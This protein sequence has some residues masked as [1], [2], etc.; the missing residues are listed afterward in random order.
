MP[1][2]RGYRDYKTPEEEG[3]DEDD[4]PGVGPVPLEEEPDFL[5]ERDE[6]QPEVS[7]D[8]REEMNKANEDFKK[9]FRE[10]GDTLEYQNLHYM[11]PLKTRKAPEVEAAIRLLYVQLR[12]EGRRLKEKTKLMA[13]RPLSFLEQEI[14][15]L[16]RTY[17]VD[18]QYDEDAEVSDYVYVMDNWNVYTW[19]ML[20]IALYYD[21]VACNYLLPGEGGEGAH[22]K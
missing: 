15:E 21:K 11:I 4:G 20:G 13:M 9:L 14:E 5:E 19:R 8:D 10:I 1:R 12:S 2:L 22:R 16:A 3:E 18:E 7:R 6:D 17:D